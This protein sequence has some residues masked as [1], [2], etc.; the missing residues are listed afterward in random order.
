MKGWAELIPY[1]VWLATDPAVPAD[2]I[3]SDVRALGLVVVNAADARTLIAAEQT[4]PARQGLF[5]LLSVGFLAAALLTVLGFLV[6]AIVSF[7]QRF[8]ELGMVRAIGLSIWQMGAFSGRRTGD[9]DS[10]RGGVGDRTGSLG[11]PHLYPVPA[12]GHDENGPGAPLCGA[13]RLEPDLDYLYCLW[14]HVCSGRL[15][16]DRPVDS[17]EDF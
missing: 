1:D 15:C 6:H 13:D 7:R 11:Q 14:R 5:G 3:V 8:I 2:Q 17:H 12:S 16:T 9:S 10:D 4:R